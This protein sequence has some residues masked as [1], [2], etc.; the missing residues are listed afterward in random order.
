MVLSVYAGVSEGPS[1][2]FNGLLVGFEVMMD[3]ASYDGKP[4]VRKR[5]FTHVGLTVA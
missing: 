2:S 1:H 5:W 4:I 3:F